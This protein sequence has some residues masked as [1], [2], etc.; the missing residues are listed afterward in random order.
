MSS[1]D[2]REKSFEKKFAHDEEIQFKVN[3]KRN[4][5][6][7]EWAADKLNKKDKSREEYILSVIKSD[8]AE[9]GDED[10]LL[11]IKKDFEASNINISDSEIRL[12][13]DNLLT[14]AK[15]DFI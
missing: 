1:F 2:E 11:K 13:M 9:P 15:K 10:V 3:A 12:Q 14:R 4:K 5:Y 6:L 8:F 7:G